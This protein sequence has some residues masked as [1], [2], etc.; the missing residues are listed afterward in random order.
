MRRGNPD[1]VLYERLKQMLKTYIRV[2]TEPV[3]ITKPGE[4]GKS[5]CQTGAII[6]KTRF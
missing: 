6:F 2:L 4:I 5:Q 3:F 1:W